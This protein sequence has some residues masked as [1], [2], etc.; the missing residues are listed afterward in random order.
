MTPTASVTSCADSIFG[1]LTSSRLSAAIARTSAAK[2]VVVSALTRTMIALDVSLTAA[3][4][5]NS[6]TASRAC[7]LRESTTA[8]SKS[9]ET[10]SAAET[11]ALPN[12]SGRDPGTN[13]LLRM[14]AG[15][16]NTI[17]PWICLL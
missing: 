17:R 11:M 10:A 3:E 12:N 5:K 14:M 16:D 6:A 1:R 8:S 4:C 15:S 2:C 7:V 13:S 9:M